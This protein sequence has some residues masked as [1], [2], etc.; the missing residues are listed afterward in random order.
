AF[1]HPLQG[2][3]LAANP[4]L[5]RKRRL[6]DDGR[7]ELMANA[8]PVLGLDDFLI[9]NHEVV[10]DL[11]GAVAGQFP[12]AVAEQKHGPVLVDGAAI[13]H[14]VHDAQQIAEHTV[15]I[16][17]APAHRGFRASSCGQQTASEG[18]LHTI[19]SVI[20]CRAAKS[21][22]RSTAGPRGANLPA[23]RT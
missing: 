22:R 8:V 19:L 7:V 20:Q 17:P 13:D 3:A 16:D 9:A 14:A 5:D 12:A 11:L 18:T 10:A 15:A 23:G 4:V 2:T 1:A 21:P 6:L